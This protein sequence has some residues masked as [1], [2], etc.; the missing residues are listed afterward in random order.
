MGWIE[1]D[2][3]GGYDY[4]NKKPLY[5]PYYKIKHEKIIDDLVKKYPSL[6]K[7]F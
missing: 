5:T 7:L 1:K 2:V 6:Q 4:V 3:R